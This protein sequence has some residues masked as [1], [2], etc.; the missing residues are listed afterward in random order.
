MSWTETSG[1]CHSTSHL[2]KFCLSGIT[3]NW[4]YAFDEDFWF[5]NYF[6]VDQMRKILY[7]WYGDAFHKQTLIQLAQRQLNYGTSLTWTILKKQIAFPYFSGLNGSVATKQLSSKLLF[8][9]S[10]VSVGLTKVRIGVKNREKIIWEVWTYFLTVLSSI[11]DSV[12]HL[13][14]SLFISG[15]HG[16]ILEMSFLKNDKTLILSIL[17]KAWEKFGGQAV[18]LRSPRPWIPDRP[19]RSKNRILI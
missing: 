15:A 1:T 3:V 16:P 10:R 5:L 6:T 14:S 2:F 13:D 9:P 17:S 19:A 8:G 11:Y 12:L 7:F 4:F 18:R